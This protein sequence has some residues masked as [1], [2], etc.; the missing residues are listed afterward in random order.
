M[1]ASIKANSTFVSR[2]PMAVPKIEVTTSADYRSIVVNGLFG[3]HRPGY[4][5]GILYTDELEGK[6]ALSTAQLAAER[7]FVKRTI[8]CRLVIDPVTAK[9]IAKWLNEH[10][11]MYEQTFGKIP[12]PE[13]RVISP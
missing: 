13:D 8:Q 3:G 1:Q 6:D 7:A 11:A 5:E 9:S 4:F 2:I 10:I 12:T